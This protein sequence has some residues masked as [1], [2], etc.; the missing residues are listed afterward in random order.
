M[1]PLDWCKLVQGWG[2]GRDSLCISAKHLDLVGRSLGGCRTR[3]LGQVSLG[4]FR[5]ILGEVR[6][7]KLGSC[8][9]GLKLPERE[10][11][12]SERYCS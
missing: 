7:Q 9:A 4:Q 1:R 5:K 3:D 2:P 8:D 11:F 10:L 6:K 12:T